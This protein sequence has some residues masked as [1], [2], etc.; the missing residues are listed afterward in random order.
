MEILIRQESDLPRAAREFLE[1]LGDRRIVAFDAPMGAGK[2]TF[3]SALCR[4]L[5]VEDDISSPTFA[6]VNEYT[7]RD[8]DIYHF[9]LYRLEDMEE[10]RD[11]GFEDYI[12]SGD[13]CL[14]EWPDIAS[15]LL[16]E[17]AVRVQIRVNDDDS[18]T[19]ISTTA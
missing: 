3:I 7:G 15:A 6:I 17:D 10:V 4:E 16:P 12:D 11:M 18:R 9:D 19:L 2:T 5:G 1:W 13:L 8:L 14:L